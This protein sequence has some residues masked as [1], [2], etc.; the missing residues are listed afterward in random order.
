MRWF[1]DLAYPIMNRARHRKASEAT[2]IP[3]SAR[4]FGELRGTRQA[5]LVTFKRSGEAVPTPVNHGLSDDGKLYFR[6]E[7]QAWKIKRIVNNPRVLIGPCNIRGK[8]AGPLA[9]GIARTLAPTESEQAHAL[10]KDNWSRA[11]RAAERSLDRLGVPEIYVEV[12][13]RSGTAAEEVLP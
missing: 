7:P 9:E 12:T 5:L 2:R 11:M 3:P 8:P 13:P 10:V 6:S 4:G 1:M